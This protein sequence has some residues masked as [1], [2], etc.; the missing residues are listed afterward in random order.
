MKKKTGFL[1]TEDEVIPG[2]NG[3]KDQSK[4]LQWVNENIEFFGGNPASVT[5][6]GTSAGSSSVHYHMISPLS[7]G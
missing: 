1:S 4:L 5:I 3:L 7:K 2:N 6:A